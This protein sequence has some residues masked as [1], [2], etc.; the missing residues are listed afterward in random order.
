[1]GIQDGCMMTRV[2]IG[3]SLTE[4]ADVPPRP[5]MASTGIR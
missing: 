3:D 1:M 4:G 2:C 5:R